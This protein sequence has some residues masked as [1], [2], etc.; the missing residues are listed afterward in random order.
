MKPVFLAFVCHYDD[1]AYGEGLPA[2]GVVRL[3]PDQIPDALKRAEQA[4]EWGSY[5]GAALDPS[6]V[7]WLSR[8]GLDETGEKLGPIPGFYDPEHDTL[9]DGDSLKELD[10]DDGVSSEGVCQLHAGEVR[11]SVLTVNIYGNDL[12]L[13]LSADCRDF[14]IASLAMP[15]EAARLAIKDAGAP[16]EAVKPA[17]LDLDGQEIA[18][19]LAALTHYVRTGQGEPDNRTEEIHLLATGIDDSV[20]SLDD[21]GIEDLLVK[22]K[23][24][25]AASEAPQRFG[26]TDAVRADIPRERG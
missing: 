24:Q 16:L 13:V 22:I 14:H 26:E 1:S 15:W 8:V 21:V 3:D 10:L 20:I 19:L 7:R 6:N 2:V 12:H 11:D 18:T 17:K 23:S 9:V 5:V 25:V 4:R